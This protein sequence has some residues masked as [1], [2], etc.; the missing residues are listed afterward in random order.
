MLGKMQGCQ[1]RFLTMLTSMLPKIPRNLPRKCRAAINGHWP[2]LGL[3]G[4]I[5]G[6]RNGSQKACLAT[7]SRRLDRTQENCRENA[8][9]KS[10]FL[11]L[12][13]KKKQDKCRNTYTGAANNNFALMQICDPGSV[14][15]L[16]LILGNKGGDPVSNLATYLNTKKSI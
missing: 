12:S 8:S 15:Q 7:S 4:V 13:A 3:Q 11:L 9:G 1:E 2:F 5:P 10:N 6:T 16:N 14:V